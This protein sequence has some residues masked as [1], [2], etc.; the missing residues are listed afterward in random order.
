MC[1]KNLSDF[2]SA[3]V[4]SA[5]SSHVVFLLLVDIRNKI[6]PRYN[7]GQLVGGCGSVEGKSEMTTLYHYE[8]KT[9]PDILDKSNCSK[10]GRSIDGSYT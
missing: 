9:S 6:Q 5:V 1:A 2:C 10:R 8:C 3:C 4:N 7:R